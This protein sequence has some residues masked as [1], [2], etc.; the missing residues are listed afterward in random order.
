MAKGFASSRR[1]M[2]ISCPF[3]GRRGD[4]CKYSFF[5]KTLL[6]S[7]KKNFLACAGVVVLENGS[8]GSVAED[9]EVK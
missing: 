8:D 6:Y 3:I 9:G 2:R 5:I 7:L 1:C 4:N